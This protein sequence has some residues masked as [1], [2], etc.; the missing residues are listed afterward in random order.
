MVTYGVWKQEPN[1]ALKLKWD[2][3]KLTSD[4]ALRDRFLQEVET[5]LAQCA[6]RWKHLGTGTAS[7]E[8]VDQ[9]VADLKQ[10]IMDGAKK[11]IGKK[12]SRVRSMAKPWW[13]LALTVAEKTRKALFQQWKREGRV[14]SL[15][16]KARLLKAK[17]I[18][19]ALNPKEKRDFLA[20]SLDEAGNGG[21]S[22]RAR[23]LHRIFRRVS[24]KRNA[25]AEFLGHR[26]TLDYVKPKV[27]CTDV[28]QVAEA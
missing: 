11:V 12:Q 7:Q 25:P 5:P 10:V 8:Q 26:A 1:R 19:K 22:G 9:A 6:G 24:S 28:S 17:K 18:Y 4:P 21:S 3:S 20:S 27:R 16:A 2:L 15:V 23:E 13:S 14:D